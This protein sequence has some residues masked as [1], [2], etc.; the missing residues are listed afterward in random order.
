MNGGDVFDLGSML[1]IGLTN[2]ILVSI[3]LYL[4]TGGILIGALAKVGKG[5][6]KVMLLGTL[7]WV[8]AVLIRVINNPSDIFYY[9]ALIIVFAILIISVNAIVDE[10]NESATHPSPHFERKGGRLE[11]ARD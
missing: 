4:I 11:N 3:V 10:Y 1:N 6:K 8:C 9:G 7:G 5:K 2:N